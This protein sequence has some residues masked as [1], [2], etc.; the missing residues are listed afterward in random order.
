MVTLASEPRACRGCSTCCVA[1]DIAALGKPLGVPCVHLGPEGRCLDYANRPE[2]CR[3]YRPDEL[4][5]A[6]AA[7]TL[8]ARVA[9][10]LALF[11]LESPPAAPRAGLPL[12]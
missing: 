3:N 6:I 8:E 11:G 2:V 9:R 5:D 1:P 7:P 12:R 10:Y 4:C